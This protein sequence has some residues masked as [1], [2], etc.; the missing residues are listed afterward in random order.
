MYAD[1]ETPAR[2]EPVSINHL[3][4]P[5]LSTPEWGL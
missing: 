3:M 5:S 4:P 2:L 1:P